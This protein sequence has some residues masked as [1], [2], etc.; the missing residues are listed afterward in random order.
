MRFFGNK[1]GNMRLIIIIV[2]GLL[3]AV[4]AGGFIFMKVL[5][6]KHSGAAVKAEPVTHEWKL[7]EL[8]VTLADT[9][10]LHYCKM[11]LT[12]VVE[13]PEPPAKGG[14]GGEGGGEGGNTKISEQAKA[15]DLLNTVV[16][17]KSVRDM[18]NDRGREKLKKELKAKLNS[19]LKETKIQT[20][21]ITYF[22]LQ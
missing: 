12:I 14:E 4:G 21:Y 11:N 19:G 20:I 15:L 17:S 5:G 8:L 22:A 6:A 13:G 1:N 10:E 9:D 3:I 2:V 7:D 16:S 18:L